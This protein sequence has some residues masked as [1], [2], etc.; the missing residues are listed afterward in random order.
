MKGQYAWATVIHELGHALGLKHGHQPG[1][2]ANTAME[3]AFDQMAYSNMTYRSYAG[4]P[5]TGYTNET[6]GYAQTFMMYDI[7]ALQTMY[8]ANLTPIPATQP[9]A[10]VRPRARCSSMASA[11]ARRVAIASS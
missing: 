10:G 3:T 8:G 11:R 2:P 4:G 7:A 6:N 5:D 1:G 9:I